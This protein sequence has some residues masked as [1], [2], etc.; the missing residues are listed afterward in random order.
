MTNH[1]FKT[2]PGLHFSTFSVPELESLLES[3]RQ[4]N[5]E[6]MRFTPTGQIAIS[7]VD[8]AD[9][10]EL[11]AQFQRFMKTIERRDISIVSCSGCG[12]C[13]YGFIDTTRVIQQIEEMKFNKA[14]P[15]KCKIA[16]AGC[17]RCCTMPFVRDVGLIPSPHGWKLI[18]GGNGGKGT[19]NW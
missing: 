16:V 12:T 3:A 9:F 19:Q 4:F 13:K 18:F 6:Q 14:L 1:N 17:A 10:P 11:I 8:E 5:I 7:G 15:A 2:V